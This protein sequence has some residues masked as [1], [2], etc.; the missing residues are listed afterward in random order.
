MADLETMRDAVVRELDR[1][2]MIQRHRGP[3]KRRLEP[4]PDNMLA[5]LQEGIDQ[6]EADIRAQADAVLAALGLDDL[7]A[8]VKRGAAQL[9]Y[10]LGD[11]P[12]G[13]EAEARA[14]L[15]AVLTSADALCECG[16]ERNVHNP[17][18]ESCWFCSTGHPFRL[19]ASGHE[20]DE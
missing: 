2:Q 20:A 12:Q 6:H 1:T 10:G 16:H 13:T 17:E 9:D 7:D 4:A 18:D 3:E 8:A 15:E 14:V 5:Q 11:H 19:A